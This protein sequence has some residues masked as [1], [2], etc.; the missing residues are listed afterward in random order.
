MLLEKH[1][2]RYKNKVNEKLNYILF[3]AGK[4]GRSVAQFWIECGCYP[5]YFL[6]NNRELWGSLCEG[7]FVYPPERVCDENRNYKIIITCQ[8][9]DEIFKQLENYGI[10]KEAII[11]QDEL[12]KVLPD[13]W[14]NKSKYY[15]DNITGIQ[16][17]FSKRVLF[18][19]EGGLVLGGVEAWA[20]QTSQLFRKKGIKAEYLTFKTSKH[21]IEK[22]KEYAIELDNIENRGLNKELALIDK[23]IHEKAPCTIICNFICSIFLGMCYVKHMR[24]KDVRLIAVIHNDEDKYYDAYT[25]MEQYID[26][27]VVLSTRMEAALLQRKF[28]KRKIKHM[29]WD[30]ACEKSLSR[31]YSFGHSKLHIGYAGRIIVKQKRMDIL[32][33]VILELIARKIDFIFEIAGIGNFMDEMLDLVKQKEIT[34]RVIFHGFIPREEIGEFWKKQDIMISCSDWEGH[35]ISQCEAMAFG[36]VPIVTDVSGARDDIVDGENGFLVDINSVHQIVEK[37]C[38][39]NEHREQ[40]QIMGEKASKTIREK[41]N[42]VELEKFWKD[43]LF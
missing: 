6:D 43:I 20:F 16:G 34:S 33:N 40:L 2:E 26:Y 21:M 41:Y 13:I 4:I 31:K 11:K 38:F 30:I 35:S 19:L 9:G 12:W 27:C 1:V 15:L 5:L 22:E 23:T 3:G 10:L 32:W 39:F 24:P 14:S 36:A 42:G 28:P 18:D 17:L 29:L 25:R 37:I 8:K 7:F